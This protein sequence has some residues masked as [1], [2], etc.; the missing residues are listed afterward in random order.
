LVNA[1]DLT[2]W[3][4]NFG[5]F[6]ASAA[7]AASADAAQSPALSASLLADEEVES[8]PPAAPLDAAFASLAGWRTEQTL[9]RTMPD[10]ALRRA[11]LNEAAW[12][13]WEPMTSGQVL[14]HPQARR[15]AGGDLIADSVEP[16]DLSVAMSEEFSEI[17]AAL[18]SMLTQ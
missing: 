8:Q 13:R 6:L 3:Q 10:F 4:N 15:W 18:S 12:E 1:A 14:Q 7:S 16:C 17:D 11:A 2:V 9:L 5:A